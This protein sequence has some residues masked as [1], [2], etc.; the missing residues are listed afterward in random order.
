MA[1]GQLR[2]NQQGA[3]HKTHNTFD[4]SVRMKGVVSTLMARTQQPIA[5]VPVTAPYSNQAGTP[6][7]GSRADADGQQR[8]ADRHRQAARALTGLVRP[9]GRAP[10]S[11][12]CW[13]K[14]LRQGVVGC[15][16]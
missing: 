10:G 16:R 13:G 7:W 11:S 1:M 9:A 15:L 12:A 5:M 14:G 4:A 8:H 3:Q 2:E 6:A